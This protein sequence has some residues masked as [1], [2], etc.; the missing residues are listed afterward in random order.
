MGR[1]DAVLADAQSVYCKIFKP[2]QP[3]KRIKEFINAHK[4]AKDACDGASLYVLCK[5]ALL[6]G[7]DQVVRL[8]AGLGEKQWKLTSSEQLQAADE[9]RRYLR[10]AA[11]F[12]WD[13]ANCG[14]ALCAV[15]YVEVIS[16]VGRVDGKEAESR[17]MQLEKALM[18]PVSH[19]AAWSD[20]RADLPPA[21]SGAKDD[22]RGPSMFEELVSVRGL[23][24]VWRLT[25][26]TAATSIASVYQ[27]QAC[28]A[29]L[30]RCQPSSSTL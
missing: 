27:A 20:P 24:L 3:D 17:L 19:Q 12:A 1:P 9:A 30:G 18:P 6:Y 29:A 4:A 21:L 7:M 8:Y 2:Q 14:S 13:G 22:D 26:Q 15:Y 28:V 25:R 11:E 5:A 16:L 10:L 23:W